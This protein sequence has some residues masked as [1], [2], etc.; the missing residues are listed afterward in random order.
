MLW[1]SLVGPASSSPLLDLQLGFTQDYAFLLR[2]FTRAGSG[3][4]CK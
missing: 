1:T 2:P 3:R 4:S